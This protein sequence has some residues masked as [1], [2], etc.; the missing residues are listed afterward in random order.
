MFLQKITPFLWFDGEAE[1]A[2]ELYTSLFQIQKSP[3][4]SG[5]ERKPNKSLA[6]LPGRP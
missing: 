1:E 3:R 5:M 6:D 4:L 2:A